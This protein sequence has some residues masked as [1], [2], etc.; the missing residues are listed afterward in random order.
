LLASPTLAIA[1][2][3]LY[4]MGNGMRSILRGT[5]PVVLFGP[6][7]YPVVVGRLALL[8]LVAQ[9]MT[10]GLAPRDRQPE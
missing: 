5:L 3:V 1:G 7:I 4:A 10:R 9:A 6:P 8:A 2:V